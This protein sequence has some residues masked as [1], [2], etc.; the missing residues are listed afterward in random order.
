MPPHILQR[1]KGFAILSVA[2]AGFI[3]SA[4]AGSGLVIAR[5]ADGGWSAPSAI[6]TAGGGFGFQA[7]V[8]MA[9]FLI[10]LK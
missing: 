9:E 8:E 3:V 1:A 5:L 2:K 7:G 6:G 4:R 10:I